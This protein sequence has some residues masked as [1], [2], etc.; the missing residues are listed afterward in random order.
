MSKSFGRENRLVYWLYP[1]FRHLILSNLNSKEPQFY[2]LPSSD[3]QG[4]DYIR[5]NVLETGRGTILQHD[6]PGVENGIIDYLSNIFRQAIAS[7]AKIFLF[8]ERFESDDGI[9]NVHMNQ[10][11]KGDFKGSNGVFQD[12]GIILGFPDGH[13]EAVFLAFANQSIHTDDQTGHSI[14]TV[15]FREHLG[16]P[17][18]FVETVVIRAALIN[19]LGPDTNSRGEPETVFLE[20][21]TSNLI[22]LDGW[23][24]GNHR[25]DRQRLDGTIV[26]QGKKL[27]LVPDCP[28]YNNEGLITLLDSSGLKVDGVSYGG[29]Q[30]RKQGDFVYFDI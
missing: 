17:P 8:G 24:I 27:F 12:G 4:L 28:L 14:G 10:G 6:L 9:H 3:K 13:F 16:V 15:D 25:G 1:N 2:P 23:S 26:A 18:I 29:G 11:S 7:K 5:G 19:P 30:G 20:N 21:R 22:N